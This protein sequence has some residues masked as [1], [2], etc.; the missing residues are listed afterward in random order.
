MGL[1][2][3]FKKHSDHPSGQPEPDPN[4]EDF[5]RDHPRYECNV[6]VMMPFR[7][8]YRTQQIYENIKGALERHGL[9]ALRADQR[10][11]ARDRQL[12]TNVTTYMRG[13]K[14]GV[15]VLLKEE[16]YSHGGYV[17]PNIT[18]E[19]GYMI[20][21]GKSVLLLKANDLYVNAD[22]TGTIWVIFD[23]GGSWSIGEEIDR[24]VKEVMNK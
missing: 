8:D 17:N 21:K 13:C 5:R 10:T 23:A 9:E 20:A 24:W 14:Y 6:F 22:M 11:Y 18:M 19:Y 3:S 4:L 15:A 12:W 16:E 7:S 1:L 2:D